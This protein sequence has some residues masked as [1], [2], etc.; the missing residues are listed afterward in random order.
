MK[1]SL[2]C[3]NTETVIETTSREAAKSNRSLHNTPYEIRML[4]TLDQIRKIRPIWEKLQANASER[5]DIEA[6]FDRYVSVVK[7]NS[8]CEPYSLLVLEDGIPRALLIGTRG[9]VTI[10]CKLG[11]FNV[12]KPCLQGITIRYGGYLG[13]F[14]ER[15]CRHLMD[16]LN[17]LLR[18]KQ[19]DVVMFQQLPFHHP[20]FCQTRKSLSLFRRNLFPKVNL[21]W[22]MDVPDTMESFYAQ[23]SS[24]TRQ[25][26]KRQLKQAS[27]QFQVR[28]AECSNADSLPEI[29]SDAVSV[30]SHTY[31]YALGWG[32]RSDPATHQQLIT[33]SNNGW[34]RLH[35]LYLDN[36]PKAFQLGL[37]YQGTYFLQSMG[38][39]PEMRKWHL[40][41]G[42]F[43]R[44]LE[45]LCEDPS[46]ERFDFG[47]GDAEYKRRF[48]S[49]QWDE[50]TI[51]MFA[52]RTYPILVS[53]VHNAVS[54]ISRG[55]QRIVQQAGIE[56]KIKQKW[57]RFLQKSHSSV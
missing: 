47:F 27:K 40:G 13:D 10:S 30:S 25:T 53:S 36:E 42:L 2:R 54:G 3:Q 4:R 56:S 12:L 23:L 41:T 50:A 43:L 39:D 7:T 48:A 16:Y 44:V 55:V 14:C 52:P 18:N 24:K 20:L 26:L 31:Q 5:T 9:P 34:L 35:V 21:H 38:F 22:R 11:Y 45:Q 15:T 32:L 17:I 8:E 19:S 28:L 29:L 33:A 57:R 49:K 37:Q 1:N 46:V 6:N 51:Y